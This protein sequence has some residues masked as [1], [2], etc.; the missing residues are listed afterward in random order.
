M[1]LQVCSRKLGH[2]CHFLN[3]CWCCR[4]GAKLCSTFAG[5]WQR[6]GCSLSAIQEKALAAPSIVLTCKPSS[7]ESGCWYAPGFST[8]MPLIPPFRPCSVFVNVCWCYRAADWHGVASLCR[9][10]RRL[11]TTMWQVLVNWYAYQYAHDFL[12]WCYVMA[13]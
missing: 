9:A 5:N 3:V 4:A 10:C 2:E 7:A 6:M 1:P 11:L 8:C 13:A 12:Q